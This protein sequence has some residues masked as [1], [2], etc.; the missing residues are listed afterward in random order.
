LGW[1]Q[2]QKSDV[3]VWEFVG[4]EK[5]IV[6]KMQ[7]KIFIWEKLMR[8]KIVESFSGVFWHF[9]GENGQNLIRNEYFL[10]KN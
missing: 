1:P 6:E 4:W 3:I 10:E 2:W 8:E 7:C 5:L 9:P